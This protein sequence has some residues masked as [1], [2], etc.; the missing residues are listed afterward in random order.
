M[1]GDCET[2]QHQGRAQAIQTGQI[3]QLKSRI[4]NDH[5]AGNNQKI[6]R[7]VAQDID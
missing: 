1:A 2:N 6:L 4:I 5:Q 3:M 7:K